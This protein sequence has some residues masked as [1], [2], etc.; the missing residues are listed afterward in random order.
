MTNC[1]VPDDHIDKKRFPLF[2]AREVL[3]VLIERLEHEQAVAL[4]EASEGA[5]RTNGDRPRNS[6]SLN[7]HFA[8][9]TGT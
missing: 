4:D 3:K 2:F 5:R 9:A 6:S 8:N 1:S 7:I